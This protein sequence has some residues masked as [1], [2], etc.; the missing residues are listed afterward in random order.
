M[1]MKDQRRW[2]LDRKKDAER[3]LHDA[4]VMVVGDILVTNAQR[5]LAALTALLATLDTIGA[6]LPLFPTPPSQER[7]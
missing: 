4:Q 1:P 5:D 6:T 2:L 7:R 3:L